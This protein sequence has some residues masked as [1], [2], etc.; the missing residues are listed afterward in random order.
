MKR[1]ALL[2]AAVLQFHCGGM[3]EDPFRRPD[4]GGRPPIVTEF[5]EA[6]KPINALCKEWSRRSYYSPFDGLH[7]YDWCVKW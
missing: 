3:S 7:Y 4:D 6:L 2:A 1:F 5:N